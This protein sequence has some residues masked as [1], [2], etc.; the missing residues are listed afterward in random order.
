MI[1]AD[2]S[3]ESG[4]QSY[5]KFTSKLI[6][7]NIITKNSL[8]N[9]INDFLE[10]NSNSN[11]YNIELLFRIDKEIAQG[12]FSY[13]K[14]IFPN[15]ILLAAEWM[16]FEIQGII[17]LS[18]GVN[19]YSIHLILSNLAHLTNTFSSGFGLAT[20]ILIAE[21]I[22]KLV[23]K[24]SKFIAVYSFLIAQLFMSVIVVFL[25][26]FRNQIFQIFIENNSD[27][28]DVLKLGNECVV[29]LA[30]FSVVDATESVMAGVFRGYGK[31]KIA[32]IIALIQYYIIQ[33]IMSWILGVLLNYKIKGIWSSIV[34]GAIS[35]TLTYFFVFIM[36]FDFSKILIETKERIESDSRLLSIERVEFNRGSFNKKHSIELTK[37]ND[38]KDIN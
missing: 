30:V 33:T 18:L 37:S 9:D 19:S 29:F 31:Q 21:K 25:I 38:I 26:I 32:S 1:K 12:L 8:D 3:E 7:N 22:G 17:A 36:Y 28:A 2:D 20:A 6:K 5:N 4:Y 27:N 13:A 15:T 11:P 16:A 24:E 10:S 14:F 23:V 35:T 34:I